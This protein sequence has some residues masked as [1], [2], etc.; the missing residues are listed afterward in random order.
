MKRT[1]AHCE[2]NLGRRFGNLNISRETRHNR[3]GAIFHK[4]RMVCMFHVK[5]A[6]IAQKQNTHAKSFP[7]ECEKKKQKSFT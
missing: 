3:R 7:F 1:S 4:A 5:H 2:A 6:G